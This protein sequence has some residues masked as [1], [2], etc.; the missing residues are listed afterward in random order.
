MHVQCSLCHTVNNAQQANRLG[1]VVCS[2]CHVTLMYALGAHSVK[3][4]VCNAVTSLGR[5]Q[6]SSHHSGDQRQQ[7]PE[8]DPGVQE[9]PQTVIVE[10]PS[11]GAG[12]TN[13]SLGVA[14]TRER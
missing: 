2:G 1:H 7:T 10:H 13:V 9:P 4:A 6:P 3:C 14:A 8:T 11:A 12:D 5:Q